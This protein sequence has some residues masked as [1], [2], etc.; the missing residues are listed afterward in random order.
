MQ[1]CHRHLKPIF[2]PW[3]PGYKLSDYQPSLS[4]PYIIWPLFL[5]FLTGPFQHY[6]M[7]PS[8]LYT[9]F[10]SSC[11]AN[12]EIILRLLRKTW[13]QT[14]QKQPWVHSQKRDATV[15]WEVSNPPQFQGTDWEFP[16]FSSPQ[17]KGK[18]SNP[19]L[20]KG[21]IE[22]IEKYFVS[23]QYLK[24]SFQCVNNM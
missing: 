4:D 23:Q 12:P 13:Y 19:T 21:F 15:P 10:V 8:W 22:R 11:P 16:I 1:V 6:L 17:S 14:L 3:L 18:S 20:Q 7:Q 9:T 5:S 24:P 2:N